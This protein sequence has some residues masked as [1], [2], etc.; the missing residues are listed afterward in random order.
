MVLD[1]FA[2]QDIPFEHVVRAVAPRRAAAHNPLFRT[3]FSYESTDPSSRSRTDG[4]TLTP[5][6]AEVGGSHFDLSLTAARTHDG[7]VLR[8]EYS[9]DLYDPATITGYLDSLTDLLTALAARPAAPLHAF[10]E[11]TPREAALLAAWNQAATAQ[12]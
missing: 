11:P 8:L 6:P 5:L 7:L 4:L 9:T 12:P 2:H 10:L 3:L 1:A